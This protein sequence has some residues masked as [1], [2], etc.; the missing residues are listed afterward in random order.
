MLTTDV[1][2]RDADFYELIG[3]ERRRI[4][5]RCL[6]DNGGS[7][8]LAELAEEIAVHETAE[9]PPPASTRN[10]VSTA[11]HR[12][13]LPEL[14]ALG[15]VRYEPDR[16]RV[17][18]EERAFDASIRFV[19]RNELSWSEYYLLIGALALVTVALSSI[20]VPLVAAVDPTV[21]VTSYVAIFTVS[22]VVHLH[23]RGRYLLARV[24]L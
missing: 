18:L 22:A 7:L 24:G 14:E 6:L 20:G 8:T 19:A 2:L 3:H 10:S 23:A 16:G 12:V 17:S 9:T 4:A 1:E 13:H 5:L 15:V 21:W 11:L